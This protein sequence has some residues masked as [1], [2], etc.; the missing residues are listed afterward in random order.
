MTSL[1]QRNFKD[2]F[3][4]RNFSSLNV[5][6]LDADIVIWNRQ[7]RILD[8]FSQK[9]LK[10]LNSLHFLVWNTET[11]RTKLNNSYVR[12]KKQSWDLFCVSIPSHHIP[13]LKVEGSIEQGRSYHKTQTTSAWSRHRP[14]KKHWSTQRSVRDKSSGKIGTLT[15]IHDPMQDDT[16]LITSSSNTSWRTDQCIHQQKR[17]F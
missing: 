17:R 11:Y 3:K 2:L 12:F 4:E 1:H 13:D 7:F 16:C 9:P 10:F 14:H 15:S 8:E 5:D 6:A